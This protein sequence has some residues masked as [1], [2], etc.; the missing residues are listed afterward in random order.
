MNTEVWMLNYHTIQ[1][2]RTCKSI[3]Y[4]SNPRKQALLSSMRQS[5]I[6]GKQ[7][8][9]ICSTHLPAT[10]SQ[11]TDTKEK[12]VALG[13]LTASWLRSTSLLAPPSLLPQSLRWILSSP[14]YSKYS[15]NDLPSIKHSK[16]VTPY[17]QS[18]LPTKSKPPSI[19]HNDLCLAWN[20]TGLVTSLFW[21]DSWG[22]CFCLLPMG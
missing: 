22:P 13:C 4:C 18:L 12:R 21:A 1:T 6:L 10:F 8:F 15:I 5:R 19:I 14:A 20:Y 16:F 17:F 7:G 3:F 9:C 11:H 2:R